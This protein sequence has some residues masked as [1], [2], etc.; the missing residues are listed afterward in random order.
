MIFRLS[1][2]HPHSATALCLVVAVGLVGGCGGSASPSPAPATPTVTASASA[3]ATPSPAPTPSPADTS[4]QASP[5]PSDAWWNGPHVNAKLEDKLPSNLA[6]GDITLWKTSV[7]LA[8]YL[9]G[10]RSG[11]RNVYTSWVVKLG[12]AP[13]DVDLAAAIDL[14]DWQIVI[15]AIEVPGASADLAASFGAEAKANGWPVTPV[16]IGARSLL[17]IT[18]PEG[19]QGR[20]LATAYVYSNDDVAFFVITDQEDLLLGALMQLP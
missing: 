12:H 16:R 8:S 17:E 13:E 3:S 4:E 14:L 9:S 15:L 20:S 11:L 19:E 5:S 10:A 18:D 7:T 2:L 1:R 6:I